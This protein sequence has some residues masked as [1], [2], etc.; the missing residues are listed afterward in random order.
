MRLLK[1]GRPALWPPAER[2]ANQL[3]LARGEARLGH[4]PAAER[5]AAAVPR[6]GSAA[7]FE[8]R[9]F[10]VDLQLDRAQERTRRSSLRRT[11]WPLPRG[12]ALLLL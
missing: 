6:D 11:R 8:A 12:R 4:A 2:A 7:D 3:A 10:G 5:A 9:L 1:S